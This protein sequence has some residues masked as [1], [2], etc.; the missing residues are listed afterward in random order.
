MV[1]V[2]EACNATQDEIDAMVAS[3]APSKQD[4]SFVVFHDNWP[5]WEVFRRVNSQWRR[6]DFTGRIDAL[7]YAA[8]NSV[9]SLVVKKKKRLET[10]DAVRLI[11]RGYLET[12]RERMN[13]G[14]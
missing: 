13:S 8:V 5:A 2:M 12:Y 4:D 1:E 9:I 7:D 10:L 14:Q 6:N 3:I 11:E